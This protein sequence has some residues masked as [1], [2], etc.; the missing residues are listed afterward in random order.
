MCVLCYIYVVGVVGIAGLD[1][2]A[3]TRIGLV[4]TTK[5]ALSRHL[6]S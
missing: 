5:I 1:V 2:H 6:Y 4:Y 3:V